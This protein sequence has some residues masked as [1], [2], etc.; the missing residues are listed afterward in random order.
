MKRFIITFINNQI[1]SLDYQTLMLP[2]LK[3]IN[4]GQIHNTSNAVT[5]LSNEFK[6]SEKELDEW[7][8][9]KKQKIFHNRGHAG[10]VVTVNW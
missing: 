6:L 7:L 5:F 1:I 9:R 8:A 10:C 2:L 4:D 3:F